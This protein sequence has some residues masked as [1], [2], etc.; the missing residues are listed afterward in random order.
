MG[1]IYRARPSRAAGALRFPRCKKILDIAFCFYYIKT[2]ANRFLFNYYLP[3]AKHMNFKKQF[4]GMTA[5]KGAELSLRAG[6][7]PSRI[8]GV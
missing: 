4:A 7:L 2:H 5:I 8:M 6:R 3:V 1:R